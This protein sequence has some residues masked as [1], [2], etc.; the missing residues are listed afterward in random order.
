MEGSDPLFTANGALRFGELKREIGAISE[1]M[2]I[3]HLKELERDQ[4]VLRRDYREVPPRVDYEL[5]PFGTSLYEA[6]MPLCKWGE[7][8]MARIEQTKRAQQQLSPAQP[9]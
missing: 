3:Q 1:K 6:L 7:A 2:L 5:T 8:H 4:V 9:R